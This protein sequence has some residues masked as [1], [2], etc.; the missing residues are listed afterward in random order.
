MCASLALKEFEVHVRFMVDV[1]V[2]VCFSNSLFA[3]FEEFGASKEN[4]RVTK[5]G[6]YLLRE[7]FN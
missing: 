6:F 5:K 2:N 1:N 7:C 4:G 3:L